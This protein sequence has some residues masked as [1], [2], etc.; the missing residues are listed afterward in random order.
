M[1]S[2]GVSL[3]EINPSVSSCREDAMGRFGYALSMLKPMFRCM[4]MLEFCYYGL[5][6]RPSASPPPIWSIS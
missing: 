3:C 6:A 5:V 2:T 1:A 4:D